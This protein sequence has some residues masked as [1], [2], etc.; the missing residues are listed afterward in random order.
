MRRARRPYALVLASILESVDL[1]SQASKAGFGWHVC[2]AGVAS[3]R[4]VGGPGLIS[5]N[6][7]NFRDWELFEVSFV[8]DCETGT[9]APGVEARSM[10]PKELPRQPG[11]FV[12]TKDVCTARTKG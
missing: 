6:G 8:R 2:R 7:L 4:A 1:G 12:P 3:Y 11:D 10:E 5:Q 9:W